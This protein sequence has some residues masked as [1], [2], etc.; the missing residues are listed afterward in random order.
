MSNDVIVRVPVVILGMCD[1][2]Y[3]IGIE[4]L[5]DGPIPVFV[6]R[7]KIGWDGKLE[8]ALILDCDDIMVINLDGPDGDECRDLLLPRA[9]CEYVC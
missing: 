8:A 9:M 3:M 7:H 1:D 5:D 6:P 4:T 2:G